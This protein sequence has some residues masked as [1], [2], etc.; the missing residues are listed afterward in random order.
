MSNHITSSKSTEL[1]EAEYLSKYGFMRRSYLKDHQPAVYKQMILSGELQSHCLEVQ[2]IANNRL[3][4]MM[5]QM[6]ERN[7]PPNKAADGLAWAV[8]MNMLKYSVEEVIFA[9]LIYE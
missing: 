9:E 3:D 6:A 2:R 4:F 7:P 1:P 8:H 5:K